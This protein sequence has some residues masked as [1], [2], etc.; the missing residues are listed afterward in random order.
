MLCTV[1]SVG[2]SCA[3]HE[4]QLCDPLKG[5]CH[6]WRIIDDPQW[7]H[8]SAEDRRQEDSPTRIKKNI[9][10]YWNSIAH[11]SGCSIDMMGFFS[12]E[13]KNWSIQPKILIL[14]H[15]PRPRISMGPSHMKRTANSDGLGTGRSFSPRLSMVRY[16][17]DGDRVDAS[18]ELSH[19]LMGQQNAAPV[20]LVSKESTMVKMNPIIPTKAAIRNELTLPQQNW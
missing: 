13:A 19:A 8:V 16:E 1:T 14:P 3:D 9:K 12:K 18:S 10:A 7:T 5:R 4:Y 2:Y 11:F 20:H 15:H 17:Q 6:A